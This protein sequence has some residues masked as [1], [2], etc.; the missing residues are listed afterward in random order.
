MVP[1]IECPRMVRHVV[2]SRHRVLIFQNIQHVSQCTRGQPG[3]WIPSQ[4]GRSCGFCSELELAEDR[5]LESSCSMRGTQLEMQGK[6]RN[7]ACS[8]GINAIAERATVASWHA[9]ESCWGCLT[10]VWASGMALVD[11]ADGYLEDR[12]SFL[13]IETN[14]PIAWTA[15][16]PSFHV[17]YDIP[18]K[19][20]FAEGRHWQ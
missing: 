18:G 10:R 3:S 12:R 16:P 15:E 2:T 5:N 11:S 14:S 4:G 13:P 9:S 6:L 8:I 7:R 20:K 1:L 17:R 19:R